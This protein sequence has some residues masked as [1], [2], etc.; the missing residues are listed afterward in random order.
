MSIERNSKRVPDRNISLNNE[1]TRHQARVLV[2]SAVVHEKDTQDALDF[3]QE[4]IREIVP[5]SLDRWARRTNKNVEEERNKEVIRLFQR[6]KE[7]GEKYLKGV[8]QGEEII[9]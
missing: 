7:V 8:R 2:F 4:H 3:Y 1:H 6:D 9:Y 5:D